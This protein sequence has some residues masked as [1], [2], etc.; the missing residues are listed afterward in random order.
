MNNK[1]GHEVNHKLGFYNALR[2]FSKNIGWC[3][4]SRT[5]R[6]LLVLLAAVYIGAADGSSAIILR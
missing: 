1:R 2:I 4:L 5:C 3:G 6:W